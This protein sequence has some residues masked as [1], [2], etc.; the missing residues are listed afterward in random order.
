MSYHLALAAL[1][2][3]TRRDLFERLHQ[4]PSPVGRLAAALPISR[5]AVSKHLK[6]LKE[7]GL[8]T[9]EADGARRIYR[10]DPTGVGPL[11]AWLDQFWDEALAAFKTEVER[12]GDKT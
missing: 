11:R 3:P 2:D 8:V 12:E 5:P 1:A 7:A 4:A 9:E 10:I 6:V